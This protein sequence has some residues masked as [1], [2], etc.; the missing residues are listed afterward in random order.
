MCWRSAMCVGDERAQIN[1]VAI[2]WNG[3]GLV[4]T[5]LLYADGAVT[6]TIIKF[7]G[8]LALLRTIS[9]VRCAVTDRH[10]RASSNALMY[11]ALCVPTLN[12]APWCNFGLACVILV[13]T[14]RASDRR[15]EPVNHIYAYGRAREG[16]W[17]SEYVASVG[18]TLRHKLC[19]VARE[20]VICFARHFTVRTI[21]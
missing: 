16:G 3:T 9:T 18:K 20:I 2:T 17:S 10:R 8:Y 11:F 1:W 4:D 19:C 13:A 12:P 14:Y 6:P 5:S 21:N 15:Y 7:T